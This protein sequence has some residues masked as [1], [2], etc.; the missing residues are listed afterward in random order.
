MEHED[1]QPVHESQPEQVVAQPSHT[2]PQPPVQ[3]VHMPSQL[4]P[5]APEHPLHEWQ[6][7]EH[8]EQLLAV[9][10]QPVPHEPWQLPQVDPHM[11]PPELVTRVP[12][13]TRMALFWGS[14]M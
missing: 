2:L 3:L 7:P 14:E 13:G 10:V 1:L 12:F 8:P 4:L 6:P 11:G 5:Q 9:D